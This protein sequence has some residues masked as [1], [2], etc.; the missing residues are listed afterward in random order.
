[1][2]IRCF[3]SFLFFLSVA[4][5][6]AQPLADGSV[7]ALLTTEWG[8]RD[9]Y[10]R[11]CPDYYTNSGNHYKCKAGCVAV[12]MA[13][14]MRYWAYPDETKEKISGY[15]N[16]AFWWDGSRI[17]YHTLEDIPAHTPLSWPLM[18]DKYGYS[19][20][21]EVG[22]PVAVLMKCCGQSVV[23]KYDR[24]S[25]AT[26]YLIANALKSKFGYAESTRYVARKDYSDDAWQR[27]LKNELQAGRPVIYGGEKKGGAGH[28]FV[29]D[30][31]RASD[32]LFHVNWGADGV[33]NGWFALDVMDPSGGSDGYSEAQD[34]IIGIMP[35]EGYVSAVEAV[36]AEAVSEG[37]WFTLSGQR[38]DYPTSPGIYVHNGRKVMIRR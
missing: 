27:L 24:S 4:C 28:S 19:E 12:A 29:I 18:Q 22:E 34:A 6:W 16:L 17:Q 30:G 7:D 25:S 3:S 10:N 26:P 1:M 13:Q 11:L 33:N 38:I 31:Y 2:L 5:C 23:M 37:Q 9:P 36:P 14:V 8:Q 35:P 20:S 15:L 32:G 21:D